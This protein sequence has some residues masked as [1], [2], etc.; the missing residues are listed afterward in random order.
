MDNSINENSRSSRII[1][2]DSY[3]SPKYSKNYVE[4][5]E[6]VS[7]NINIP[8]IPKLKEKN[9]HHRCSNCLSF[10]VIDFFEKNEEYISYSCFCFHNKKIKIEELFKK[11]KENT[12]MTFFDDNNISFNNSKNEKKKE[13][14]GFKCTKHKTLESYNKFEYYSINEEK[15]EGK[16]IC[17]DCIPEHLNK[18]HHLVVFAFQNFE[19][20]KKIDEILKYQNEKEKE[21]E[22]EQEEEQSEIKI[23]LSKLEESNDDYSDD[24]KNEN[25]ILLN[26]QKD[27]TK[28]ET[29]KDQ[30]KIHKMFNKLINIIINDYLNYPNYSHFF[31]IENI[32]R[33][34]ILPNKGKEIKKETEK[35]SLIRIIFHYNDSHSN[36]AVEASET[37]GKLK[38]IFLNKFRPN[39]VRSKFF[40]NGYEL[41]E[42][43]KIGEIIT[44]KDKNR[45]K[46]EIT[47]IEKF[48]V[49]K[50]KIKEIKCPKCKENI[51]INFVNY[52][53]NLHSC[54]NKHNKDEI[55]LDDFMK[56]QDL[57][58]LKG[59][60]CINCNKRLIYQDSFY[61]CLNCKADLCTSCKENHDIYHRIFDYNEI[62]KICTE[63]NG[64]F[65]RYCKT[66]NKNLCN[67]CIIC[68]KKHL[69]HVC[70]NFN[71]IIPNK[72]KVLEE[73]KN[74]KKNIEKLKINVNIIITKLNTIIHNM[75][76][77]D[78]IYFELINAFYRIK[79]KNYQIISNIIEFNKYNHIINTD[80]D[81]IH[82]YLS[83]LEKFKYLIDIYNKMACNSYIIGDI[84]IDKNNLN[85]RVR[86]I[87]SYEQRIREGQLIKVKHDSFENEKE[88]K[89][90]CVI[91][92]DNNP[93]NFIY[94]YK[95]K[96]T[97][98][99][100]IKYLFMKN[101]AN[102]NDLF[103]NCS[104]LIKLDL[105]HFN[106]EYACNMCSM[107]IECKRLKTINL[108][109][110]ITKNVTNMSYMF[111]QCENLEKL[112]VSNFNIEK[113]IDMSSFISSCKSLKEVNFINFNTKNVIDLSWMFYGCKTLVYINLFNFNTE[114][115]YYMETMFSGLNKKKVKI[116]TKD[117]KIL[118]ELNK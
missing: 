62:D 47:I 41:N 89:E 108:S 85:D 9:I 93:I 75:E 29:K 98:N 7:F 38:K 102:I 11:N 60:Q 90:N 105:S 45:N 65:Y 33:V 3:F 15:D 64:N 76:L 115:A 58:Y 114:N 4:E 25:V 72:E 59:V 48:E 70:I 77:Y 73:E 1:F 116:I 2:S 118:K 23:N 61:K 40:Y 74:L 67:L 100:K 96:E 117:R 92:I 78:K 71:D 20:K 51:F 81:K 97:G 69:N 13:I 37:V 6:E 49:D 107:F 8:P 27:H 32:Y 18:G 42:E 35:N 106:S 66:C 84:L 104:S 110:L 52:K 80:I 101:I 83:D 36:Y 109:N 16:N 63:H 56:T 31:T 39:N 54:K 12:F 28:L 55:T 5:E 95:F 94:F 22:R 87:N 34:L 103:A 26:I 113:V 46:M 68:E 88:L 91:L 99:Y 17:E 50:I 14:V 30:R 79:H 112:D 57:S 24:K 82:N 53:I 44:E 86:I 111:A 10:P 21:I 19:T 43:L